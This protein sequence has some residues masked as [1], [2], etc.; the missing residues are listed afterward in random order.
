MITLTLD[1]LLSAMRSQ[2]VPQRDVTFQ[3]PRCKTLQ[4][5]NDLIKAGAG[6]NA[7]EVAKYLGF[8]CIGRFDKSKGC[9]WTLGGLL[10]IHELEVIL[11]SGKL[12]P[13]FV[14]ISAEQCL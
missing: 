5:S 6:K 12:H 11:P 2:N 7:I 10:Q 3:C 4:S 8:S 9:D 1:E 14:P 13:F